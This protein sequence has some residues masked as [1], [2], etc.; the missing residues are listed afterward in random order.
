MVNILNVKRKNNQ[1]IRHESLTK[2]SVIHEKSNQHKISNSFE[3]LVD[4][5]LIGLSVP[6]ILMPFGFVYSLIMPQCNLELAPFRIT[7]KVNGWNQQDHQ[8][9]VD[10]HAV[11]L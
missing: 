10:N 3:I 7:L 5:K 11:K 8:S 9:R 1:I 4:Q 2:L 6:L